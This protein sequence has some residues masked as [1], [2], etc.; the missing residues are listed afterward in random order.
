VCRS[1]V[2]TEFERVT[3]SHQPFCKTVGGHGDLFGLTQGTLPNRRHAPPLLLLYLIDARS[4]PLER[5][6]SGDKPPSRAALDA[7]ADMVGFGIVFPGQKDRSGGYFSVDIEAPALEE[8]EEG[9]DQI[10]E[11]E[12]SDA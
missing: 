2:F 1:L 9:E 12:G 8:T 4:E 10:E 5:K 3:Y 6:S 7:V 11:V